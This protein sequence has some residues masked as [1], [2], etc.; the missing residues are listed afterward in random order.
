MKCKQDSGGREIDHHTLQVMRQQ[1][2]KAVKNGQT[3]AAMGVNIRTVFRWLS[4]FATGGQNAF[5]AK[6]ITGRP[7][8]WTPDEMCWIAETVT[9]RDKTPW[10]M[11]LEFGLWTLSLIGE[12]IYRQF[13]KRLTS[14]SVGRIMRLLG[15]T[16]QKPLYCAW[17]QDPFLMEKWQAEAFPALKTEARRTGAVIYFADEAGVRSDFHAGPTWAPVARTPT[18]K[19]IGRRYGLNLISAVSA[20]GDFRFMVQEGNVTAE[21]FIE[22]LK[23]LLRGAEQP[24]ILVVDGLRFTRPRALKLLCSNSKAGCSWFF[25]HRT[26]HNSI[27]MNR[28][29]AI[30]SHVWPSRCRKI[31]SN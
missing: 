11:R 25:C 24:I 29:G 6:K 16:P 10:Q 7:L 5:L 23:R 21:V 12:F 27:R 17:Q 2:V 18:V 30:S 1:A 28:F 14:P 26:R 13:G 20:R 9:V 19:T 31:K 15:F 3:E 4:D 8:Q 22:F